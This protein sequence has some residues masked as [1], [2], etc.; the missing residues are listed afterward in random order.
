MKSPIEITKVA[1]REILLS[2]TI[3]GSRITVRTGMCNPVQP[4][5]P[6]IESLT[7]KMES[8]RESPIYFVPEITLFRVTGSYEIHTVTLLA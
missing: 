2:F 1:A 3:F 8:V 4:K 6:V 5:H 7:H